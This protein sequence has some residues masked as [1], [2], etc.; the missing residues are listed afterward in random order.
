MQARLGPRVDTGAGASV[1][2]RIQ[3][4]H[5][6]ALNH[7]A[8][9]DL[10]KSRWY[11]E[12]AL[13]PLKVT[14]PLQER[15]SEISLELLRAHPSAYF[16]LRWQSHP[17]FYWACKFCGENK[18]H[19]AFAN[20]PACITAWNQERRESDLNRWKKS[21][22]VY[23]LCV[24]SRD[25]VIGACPTLHRLCLDC[26][27]RGHAPSDC[28]RPDLEKVFL[29]YGPQGSYTRES[30]DRGTQAKAPEPVWGWNPLGTVPA[31][32]VQLLVGQFKAQW[33]S[34]GKGWMGIQESNGDT[35]DG[36]IRRE[37]AKARGPGESERRSE[38]KWG[39]GLPAAPRSPLPTIAGTSSS[40]A[41][42]TSPRS[43]HKAKVSLRSQVVVPPNSSLNQRVA[44]C[45]MN[46]SE[47]ERDL[48]QYEHT[49]AE[50]FEF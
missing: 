41:L 11:E 43:N 46:S 20:C 2:T 28:S 50:D 1:Y 45:S 29:I 16:P 19:R 9:K 10:G 25:H 49:M 30:F 8:P 18:K 23:P 17:T 38:G 36:L 44:D 27:K 31:V 40:G 12:P 39:A 24:Q 22:C 3:P 6:I 15:E 5:Q 4:R 47:L 37:H 13:H 33:N 32:P 14:L 26:G 48:S 7:Q 35:I 34:W 21:H 42:E